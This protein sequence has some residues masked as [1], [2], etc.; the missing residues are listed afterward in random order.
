MRKRH[1]GYHFLLRACAV[2]RTSGQPEA[3]GFSRPARCANRANGVN[4][5][6]TKSETSNDRFILI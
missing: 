2:E 1:S 6:T 5:S 3:W 4:V